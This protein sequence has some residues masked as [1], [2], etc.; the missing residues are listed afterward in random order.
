[1]SIFRRIFDGIHA[2]RE[3]SSAIKMF[4][5]IREGF[6]LN[7][8]MSLH[9]AVA[10]YVENGDTLAIGGFTTNRKPYATVSEILRQ[11]QKDFIVYAGPGGGEVDML[12]G[13]GRVAAYIN[14]Y[15][16]NS[17]YT[18]VSR[19]FRAAIEAGK[20]TYEDYSQDVLMLQL[21]AASLGLPF[22]PV[23]LMQGSGLTK[24]WGIS[25]EQRAEMPSM[26]NDKYVM[27]DNPFNP[28][29]QVVAVPVPKLDTAI[30]HVQKA[31]PDGTCI[32][33][34]DEF[35]DVDVAVAAKK[36]IVTCEELV[37][38]EY[39]R[40]DPTLTRVFGECVSAVV[41]APYGAWPSQCYNYYDCDGNALKEYDKASKY[42]DAEDAKVQLAKAAAKAA[43]TAAAKPD[44][45]KAAEAA[46]KAAAA[47][48]AAEEGTAIPE[49]FKDYLDKWVYGVKDNDELL[50]VIGGAR[51]AGLKVVP[52]LGYAGKI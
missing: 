48:K 46:Q 41:H 13:E 21:H 32:I 4:I 37:S 9:D 51:L 25:K 10:K 19:R 44:D 29:E 50:N 1:M 38:D 12:I 36:V 43:K 39:I 23:R 20:L 5:K 16:A 30:I 52:G 14:C 6:I 17:G 49:T 2:S 42:Q 18:N 24:Y 28:G 47:A 22:L 35:H 3:G 27:V 15:T 26:D 45:A 31:S 40:R 11:G 34:G 33:E 7:K 8:V